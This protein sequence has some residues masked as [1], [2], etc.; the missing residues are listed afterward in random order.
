[1]T[2]TGSGSENKSPLMG[3]KEGKRKKVGSGK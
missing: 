1:M 3:S 2:V